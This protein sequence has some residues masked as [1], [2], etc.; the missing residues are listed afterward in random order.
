MSVS[1]ALNGRPG[2]GAETVRRIEDAAR[3]LGFRRNTL[4]A[5]LRNKQQLSL[6]GMIVPDPHTPLF[7]SIAVEVDRLV[8]DEGLIVVTASSDRDPVKE[9]G[10]VQAFQRRGFDGIL[11]FS[12]DDDHSYIAPELERGRPIIFLGSVPRGVEAPCVLVDNRGGARAAVEHLLAHGHRRIGI[13]AGETSFPA[14][15]RLAGYEETLAAHGIAPDPSLIR[16][17]PRLPE[18]GRAAAVSLL[19]QAEPA[20]AIFSTNYPLTTG[21][22]DAIRSRSAPVALVGFDDFEAAALVEP[23]IT[24][25]TQDP[26]AMGRHAAGMLRDLMSASGGDRSARTVVPATLIARGSGELAPEHQL[27]YR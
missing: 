4:A 15:E 26:P 14:S 17:G 24:V 6:I 2:V 16:T 11:L 5:S 25:I 9:R 12:E 13:V 22:L 23:P 21:I 8:R 7:T 27:R 10:L 3:Q 18:Y 19:A 1:R 20:T